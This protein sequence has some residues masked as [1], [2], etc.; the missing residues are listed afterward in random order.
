VAGWRRQI[1]DERGFTLIE[2]LVVLLII[3]VLAAIAL[4]AFLSSRAD[5]A[6]APAKE[7]LHTAQVAAE[8]L[9]IDYAGSYTAVTAAHLRTYEPTIVTAK[10]GS[11][12]YVSAA[13]GT[14]AGYTL[15]VVS[16]ITGNKYTVVRAAD[17][18]LERT[19]AIPKKTSP[20]GGCGH[21]TG[22]KGTW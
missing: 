9:D 12:P 4:P 5:A 7:L 2:L 17:G 3:G 6:D 13:K 8:T 14:A 1:A 21:V 11:A 22:T 19:C 18:T 15:T 10:N 16:P 20:H